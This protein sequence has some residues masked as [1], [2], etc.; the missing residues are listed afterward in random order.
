MDWPGFCARL[1][2]IVAAALLIAVVTYFGFP[3]VFIYYS[4]L[5]IIAACSLIGL[6]FLRLP[7]IIAA[8]AAVGV[9]RLDQAA[10]FP[11]ISV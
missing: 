6:M 1:V 10:L 2:K 5:H 4:I 9:E 7:A 8:L 3:E 11:L